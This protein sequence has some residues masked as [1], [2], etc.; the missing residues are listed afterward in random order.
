MSWNSEP[1]SCFIHCLYIFLLFFL[2]MFLLLFFFSAPDPSPKTKCFGGSEPWRMYWAALKQRQNSEMGL[3]YSSSNKS[4]IYWALVEFCAQLCGDKAMYRKLSLVRSILST[5]LSLISPGSPV[6][7]VSLESEHQI[8]LKSLFFLSVSHKH[9]GPWVPLE[10][11]ENGL[12]NHHVSFLKFNNSLCVS[13]YG[14]FKV[15]CGFGH[16]QSKHR[17]ALLT[18]RAASGLRLRRWMFYIFISLR[19]KQGHLRTIFRRLSGHPNRSK[20]MSQLWSF[21]PF[22]IN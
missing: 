6:C 4:F 21:L 16:Y 1:S 17:L 22:L 9:P 10:Y 15:I 8:E 19:N 14:D 11:T 3:G 18:K 12:F 7:Y 5:L 20:L 2:F 13:N